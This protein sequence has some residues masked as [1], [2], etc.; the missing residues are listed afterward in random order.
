[1]DKVVLR[2][3]FFHARLKKTVNVLS[4]Q[5]YTYA[6]F[7]NFEFLIYFTLTNLFVDNVKKNNGSRDC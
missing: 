2:R 4:V 5:E 7:A 1:V 6:F 3:V